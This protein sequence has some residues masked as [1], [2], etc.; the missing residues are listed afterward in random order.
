M[1]GRFYQLAFID[2]YGRVAPVKLYGRKSTL[3]AADLFN[4]WMR[5]WFGPQEV[6]LL[7]IPLIGA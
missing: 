1:Q 6:S 2:T 5:L 3:T 7:R 4:G